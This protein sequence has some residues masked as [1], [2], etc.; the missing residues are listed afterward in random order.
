[1]PS[2][3]RVSCLH[4]RNWS[5]AAFSDT[6]RARLLRLLGEHEVAVE[7]KFSKKDMGGCTIQKKDILKDLEKLKRKRV[8]SSYFGIVSEVNY[9]FK[10]KS[11]NY[12]NFESLG[13]TDRVMV[14][15]S[16]KGPYYCLLARLAS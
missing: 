16:P 8:R 4:C 5:E 12:V 9:F 10:P 2:L 6:C 11:E 7:L 14:A 3:P 13:F 15:R 1:V